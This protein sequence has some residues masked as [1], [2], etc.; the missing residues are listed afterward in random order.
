MSEP[1][2]T[3]K[4][5]RHLAAGSP[6]PPIHENR[7]ADGRWVIGYCF[8]DGK[9][10]HAVMRRN[11]G[12]TS[13]IKPFTPMQ[14]SIAL[15]AMSQIE[16]KANVKFQPVDDPM[17]AHIRFAGANLGL[18]TLGRVRQDGRCYDCFVSNT[19]HKE[20]EIAI[21]Q[22]WHGTL[23]HEIGHAIG[24]QHPLNSEWEW[25]YTTGENG[26]IMSYLNGHEAPEKRNALGRADIAA[27]QYVYG[28][29][30]RLA[31]MPIPKTAIDKTGY[32]SIK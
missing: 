5:V 6:F 28:E 8:I 25:E 14:R 1:S 32:K 18:S 20:K 11:L 16:A 3:V 10:S 4:A 21:G 24:L 17:K 30:R 13:H 9:S 26:S 27:L 22:N 7:D 31:A 23:L 15:A 19:T 12:K 2:P 29:P